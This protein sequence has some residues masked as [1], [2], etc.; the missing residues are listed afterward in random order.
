MPYALRGNTVI[1]RATG[2]PVPG[3][4]HPTRRQ[5]R[6]HLRAL[7]ANVP[8]AKGYD[9]PP[10]RLIAGRLMRGPYGR[11][12]TLDALLSEPETKAPNYA[13]RAG[14]TI[15]GRLARGAGGKF[16]AAGSSGAAA[17]PKKT[18]AKA[19]PKKRPV[20]KRGKKRAAPK[21]AA[22]PKKTPEQRATE[23][24]AAAA[25]KLAAQRQSVIDTMAA[26]DAGLAPAG[27]K[28]LLD[29]ADGKPV[30][31]AQGAALEKMGLLERDTTGALRSSSAGKQAAAS[32]S[33]GDTRGALDAI[34]RGQDAAARRAAQAAKPKKAPKQKRG[35]RGSRKPKAAPSLASGFGRGKSMQMNEKTFTVFKDASGAYRWLA[36]TTT[37]YRDRDGEIITTKALDA[38]AQRMTRT[39]QFGPLRYWHVGEPDPFDLTRPWGPGLDIGDC[40]YSTVIGQTALESGTFKSAAIGRA[41]A[42]HASDYELSPGFFHPPDQPSAAGD[43]DTIRRFERSVVPTQ[44]GRAS[45]LF[46]GMT[47]KENRSMDDATYKARVDA[48]LKDMNAKGVPAD[49]AA[50]QLASMER[51]DKSAEQQ[52]IAYKSDDAADPWAA[53]VAALKAALAPAEKA[54]G[55]SPLQAELPIIAEDKA[56]MDMGAMDGAAVDPNAAPAEDIAVGDMTPAEFTA[57]LMQAFQDAIQQFGSSITTQMSAIDEAVKGMGYART[58]SESAQAA[59]V[60]AVEARVARLEGDQP[61]VVQN[62]DVEAAL[63]S[64]GPQSPP[65]PNALPAPRD[66]LHALAMATAPE[67]Y[68]PVQGF[69]GAN[70]WQFA[71]PPNNEA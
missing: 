47:V 51:A 11:F 39:R 36:R 69:N 23:R 65:D 26:S 48:F 59:A 18:P 52:G 40:D 7:W 1:N 38:D 70:G 20:R 28:A 22:A 66:G 2:K 10:G 62:A 33:K 12:S 46:T 32:M 25:Q 15:V 45:N 41:F 16:A 3:G 4:T 63:K 24:Q 29:F 54:A 61:A 60:A 17:A 8:E 53:V 64:A 42:E 27:A 56:P 30:S 50:G 71:Q 67:L 13:A 58:K 21:K 9:A 5:A 44:Y 57:L 55:G 49:V 6:A 37:A 14:G 68:R 43:Y 34:S 35:K 19:A 31:P